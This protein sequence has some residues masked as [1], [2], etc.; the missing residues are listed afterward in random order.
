[1]LNFLRKKIGSTIDVAN[2]CIYLL[3]DASKWVTGT[4]LIIGGGHS[5]K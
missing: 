3:S 5:A 2:G 1:M 4:N